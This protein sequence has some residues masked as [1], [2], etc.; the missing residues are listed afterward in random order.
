MSR[1]LCVAIT[2]SAAEKSRLD[3]LKKRTG[4]SRAKI[5]NMALKQLLD[6]LEREESNTWMS[7]ALAT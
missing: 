6:R 2:L 7:G 3:A 1:Q 4:Y 5:L